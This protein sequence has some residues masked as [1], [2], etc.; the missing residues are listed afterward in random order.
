MSPSEEK[1]TAIKRKQEKIAQGIAPTGTKTIVLS[2]AYFSTPLAQ[3][4][5]RASSTQSL[6]PT[7]DKAAG[8]GHL[9]APQQAWEKRME[10]DKEQAPKPRVRATLA[11][12]GV[13]LF[14][15]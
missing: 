11:G 14:S 4:D 3:K 7:E 2:G 1:A 13:Y 12:L 10:V 5:L 6:C 15:R 8:L 9:R